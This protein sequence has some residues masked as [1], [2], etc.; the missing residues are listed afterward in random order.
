ML[1][2]TLGTEW[3]PQAPEV[4]AAELLRPFLPLPPTSLSPFHPSFFCIGCPAWSGE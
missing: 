1:P 4:K 2:L 3:K